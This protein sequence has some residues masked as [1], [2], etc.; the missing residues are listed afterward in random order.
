MMLAAPPSLLVG[1]NVLAAGVE[2]RIQAMAL[3]A[4]VGDSASRVLNIAA[5]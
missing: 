1:S 5:E 4:I 2:E 3:A